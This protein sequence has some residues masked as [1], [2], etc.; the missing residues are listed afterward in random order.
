MF[1]R[2]LCESIPLKRVIQKEPIDSFFAQKYDFCLKTWEN[3]TTNS[4]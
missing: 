4:C 1:L 2:V 3:L